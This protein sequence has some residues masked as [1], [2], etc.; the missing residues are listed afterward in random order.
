MSAQSGLEHRK[1]FNPKSPKYISTAVL[2]SNKSSFVIHQRWCCILVT[3]SL[4]VVMDLS[5]TSC[6]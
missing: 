6:C 5:V 1:F 4:A 3:T 2:T